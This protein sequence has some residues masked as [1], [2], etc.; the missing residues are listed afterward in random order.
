MLDPKYI[1]E[2]KELVVK[3]VKD[4][5][6]EGEIDVDEFLSLYAKYIDKLRVVE[7]HRALKN[8]LSED[9][10]KADGEEREK[11]IKEAT[12]V[13]E[14]LGGMEDELNTLEQNVNEML[15]DIP[16]VISE[17]VP[18]GKDEAE[19]KVI[20]EWGKKP[21][22]DFTP[23]DHVELG[24]ILDIIDIPTSAKVSGAR[25]NYLKNE[26]VLLQFALINFVFDILSDGKLVAKLSK[27][28]KNPSDRPFT[29]VLPPVIIKEEV[30]KKMDRFDPIDDR[31]YLEKDKQLLIGSAEHSL[32]PIY[33][34]EVLDE[35]DLPIRFIGYSTAFRRE[36]GTYGKDM[37]GILRRHQFD[38]LEMESFTTAETGAV[39]QDLIIEIQ[40]YLVKQLEIPYQVVILC[41]GDMGKA[42]YKQV[43]INCWMPGENAYRETHTSDYMTDYQARRLNT[44]YKDKEGK[45]HFVH[46]NDATAFAIGRTLIAIIEN[47]QQKDG[48]VIVP[49]VL[50]KYVDFKIIEPK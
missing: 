30:A 16:N 33:M 36:A 24:K 39:E 37:Q 8:Q 49:D 31:Y 15:Y 26:A 46:M 43:D 48:S 28:A 38:K 50:R 6:L 19:N 20:R 22:F 5:G 35:K 14:E 13:K 18:F 44:R 12:D 9:I 42:D 21:E 45:L 27:R 41:T 29:P 4:K 47:Y 32:G 10:A 25:F 40:E 11:L 23:K 2:N 1:K 17:D 3:A 7:E 34:D